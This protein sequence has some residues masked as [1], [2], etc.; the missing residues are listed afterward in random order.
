MDYK[1]EGQRKLE[2]DI[3]QTNHKIK[4]AYNYLFAVSFFILI[5]LIL[6]CVVAFR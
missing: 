6:S 5:L 2:I 4:M 3:I 1:P